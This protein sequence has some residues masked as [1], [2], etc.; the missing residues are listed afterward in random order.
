MPSQKEA[1][2]KLT[3]KG[4][5]KAAKNHFAPAKANLAAATSGSHGNYMTFYNWNANSD[6][7][8]NIDLGAKLAAGGEGRKFKY[9]IA[10]KY[11]TYI[12]TRF[13]RRKNILVRQERPS[14]PPGREKA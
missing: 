8:Y 9:E 13:R 3:G 14:R 10:Q 12:V 11:N 6:Y 7:S 5:N 1:H 4:N 2:S